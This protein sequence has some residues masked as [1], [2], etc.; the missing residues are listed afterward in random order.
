MGLFDFFRKERVVDLSSPYRM[1]NEGRVSEK[2]PS[3]DVSPQIS[4]S[5]MFESLDSGKIPGNFGE[6]GADNSN[7][8]VEERRK[9][10]AKRLVNI[11]E[12]LDIL[13]TQLYHLQ[14]RIELLEK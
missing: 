5:G 8:S 13:S 7:E 3:K 11:T 9:K 10:L 1:K 14:Q 4:A 12:R 6:A 2:N